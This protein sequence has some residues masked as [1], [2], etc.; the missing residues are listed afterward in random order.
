MEEEI[1]AYIRKNDGIVCLKHVEAEF[2]YVSPKAVKD[3]VNVLKF[4]GKIEEGN[5]SLRD[6]GIDYPF[7]KVKGI[8]VHFN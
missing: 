7:F 2:H 1:F 6:N 8:K 5:G 3:A 4:D